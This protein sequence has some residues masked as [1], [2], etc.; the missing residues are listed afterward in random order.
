MI[1]TVCFVSS[2][3]ESVSNNINEWIKKGTERNG[4]KFKLIDV[5]FAATAE[6]LPSDHQTVKVNYSALVIYDDFENNDLMV[7]SETVLGSGI[8]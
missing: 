8:D 4:A 5:K 1:K 2:N 3:L 7:E 6:P